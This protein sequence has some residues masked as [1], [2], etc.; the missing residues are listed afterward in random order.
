M[1]LSPAASQAFFARALSALVQIGPP[2]RVRKD[3]AGAF[4]LAKALAAKLGPKH[5]RQRH[6]A[7]PG[8]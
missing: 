3:V 4:S 1:G 2:V 6:L 5:G 8:A 7:P